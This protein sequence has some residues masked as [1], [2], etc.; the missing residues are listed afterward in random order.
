MKDVIVHWLDSAGEESRV[1]LEAAQNIDVYRVAS[2]GVLIYEDDERVNL[3]MEDYQSRDG[4]PTLY[5]HNITIP[6]ISI[7]FIEEVEKKKIV[8]RHP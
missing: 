6:K 7:L 3:S 8:Y 2:R 4:C 1:Y 5:G